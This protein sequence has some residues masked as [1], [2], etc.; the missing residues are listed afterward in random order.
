MLRLVAAAG[1]RH[2]EEP[3]AVM[4]PLV[5]FRTLRT[6]VSRCELARICYLKVGMSGRF[7]FGLSW[8]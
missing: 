8:R 5:S 1:L 3:T 2:P 4:S 6:S 7:Q